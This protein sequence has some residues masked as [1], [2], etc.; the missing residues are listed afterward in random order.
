MAYLHQGQKRKW[1][2]QQTGR[3]K[4]GFQPRKLCRHFQE[5]TCA[6]GDQCS[7]AHSLEELHPDE[8]AAVSQGD[9]DFSNPLQVLMQNHGKKE[10]A[11]EG[12]FPTGFFPR[13]LCQYFKAGSCMHGT[14]C[15][16]AHG[17]EE[18]HPEE[19]ATLGQGDGFR[20]PLEALL[21]DPPGKQQV[22]GRFQTG[23]FPRRM[24]NYFQAGSCL[25]GTQCSFAHGLDE[26]HPDERANFSALSGPDSHSKRLEAPE[27]DSNPKQLAGRFASGF[28]PRRLC[29]FF[30][31]GSCSKG[32]QC[33]FAHGL[34]ELHPDERSALNTGSNDEHLPEAWQEE[35]EEQ[36]GEEQEELSFEQALDDFDEAQAT[37][38]SASFPA[39]RTF[40]AGHVPKKFCI[41][42]LHHPGTCEAAE[43][44]P[45]AH[46]LL[47][48]GRPP[49]AVV[50]RTSTGPGADVTFA[51]TPP[52][53]SPSG[54][55]P[56]PKASPKPSELVKGGKGG[57]TPTA[58]GHQAVP[59]S[60][61]WQA[62]TRAKAVDR[63]AGSDFRP[64]QLCKFF[65]E[66]PSNCAK[67]NDCNFAHGA[68]ELGI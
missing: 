38:S 10:V 28:L 34:D 17:L 15:R 51:G 8:R 33:S 63:F 27:K 57:K 24:C 2:E 30:Q 48:M 5:G 22:E 9:G 14:Q 50:I 65:E 67:G 12:R 4:M 40:Q 53:A 19:R 59:S 1:D 54:A 42:W 26:L 37:S 45:F 64:R 46:G 39:P 61:G 23:F 35:E 44:C 52:T 36:A 49:Q 56:A 32:N 11:G 29:S 16:F 62:T 68:I 18:L 43:S 60:L 25:H 55:T 6:K 66:H 41:A 21:Q 13:R 47:E 3:F 20:N 58:S 31:E 7:F